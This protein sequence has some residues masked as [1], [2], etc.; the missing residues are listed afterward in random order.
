MHDDQNRFRRY[1]PRADVEQ[2]RRVIVALLRQ[3]PNGLTAREIGE[4]TGLSRHLT[5]SAISG[6]FTRGV[7]HKRGHLY[8]LAAQEEALESGEAPMAE[9]GTLSIVRRGSG[10]QVRYAANHPYDPERP[11]HACDDEQKL[12]AFL[13]HLGLEAEAIRQACTTVQTGGVA[14]LRI[15]LSPGQRQAFFRR[16]PPQEDTILGA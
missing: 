10:Y 4:A 8:V 11:P 5:A 3:H 2:R 7:L 9:E 16:P 14:V 6:L 1:R 13:H 12:I 15:L